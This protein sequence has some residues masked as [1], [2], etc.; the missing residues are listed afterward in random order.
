MVARH[1]AMFRDWLEDLKGKADIEIVT[2]VKR[3]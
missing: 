3:L 1:Q 2:P